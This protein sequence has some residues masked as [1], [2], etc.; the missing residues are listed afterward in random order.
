MTLPILNYIAEA[1]APHNLPGVAMGN[2]RYTTAHQAALYYAKGILYAQEL[3]AEQREQ[4]E[5][6]ADQRA[7]WDAV[8]QWIEKVPPPDYESTDIEREAASAITYSR[9][10]GTSE[11]MQN[12]GDEIPKDGGWSAPATIKE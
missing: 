8:F 11:G 9:W 4:E 7:L 6:L 2:N 3:A 1:N 5:N 10:K 12:E